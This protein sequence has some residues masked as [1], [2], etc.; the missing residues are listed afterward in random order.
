MKLLISTIFLVLSVSIARSDEAKM[1]KTLKIITDCKTKTGA[2]DGDVAKLMTHEVPD[3]Q[4]AKC[5]FSCIMD[6]MGIV[7]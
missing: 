1:N 6:A 7:S 3:N 4:N 2:S 5:M